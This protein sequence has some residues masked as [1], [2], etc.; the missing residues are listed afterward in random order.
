[1]NCSKA[2]TPTTKPGV[3][4][5]SNNWAQINADNVDSGYGMETVHKHSDS[6]ESTIQAFYVVYNTLG[7]G[8]AEKVYENAMLIQFTSQGFS[9]QERKPIYVNF[10]GQTVGDY[11]IDLLVDNLVITE[12]KA[13]KTLLPEHEAQLLNYLKATYDEVGLLLNFGPKP[14]I[15]RKAFNNGRKGSLSWTVK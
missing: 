9:V 3:D 2:N 14:Q 13:V 6:T 12:L 1:V 5:R 10:E 11:F 15:K 7:Y 4:S 8:F